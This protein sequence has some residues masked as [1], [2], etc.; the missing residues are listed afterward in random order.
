MKK[1][2]ARLV[3]WLVLGASI[4]QVSAQAK[5][6]KY[7]DSLLAIANKV[8]PDS[9]SVNASI[10]LQRYFF[11]RGRFD[12]ALKYAQQA[13]PIAKVV[14]TKKSLVRMMYRLGVTHTNLGAYDSAKVY[15]NEAIVSAVAIKDT[16]LE[17]TCY[18][19]FAQLSSYQSD[20][21]T[22]IEYSLRAVATID[23]S[24]SIQLKNLL[25]QTY[26]RIAYNFVNEKQYAKAIEYGKKG[27]IMKGYPSEGRH[28]TMLYLNVFFAY[29]E[30]G[31]VSTRK[32][33]LDS[34][35]ITNRSL[36][37]EVIAAMVFNNEGLYY[38]KVNDFEKAGMAYLKS[39]QLN[40]KGNHKLLQSEAGDNLSNIFYKTKNYQQ[41]EKYAIE[42]NAIGK[43]LKLYQVVASTYNVLK[44]LSERKGDF[45]NALAY[46]EQNKIYADSALNQET[47]KV[48]LSL[49]SKYQNQ[50]KEREIAALTIAN[51]QKE[52][53]VVKRN[54][55]LV[56]GGIAA[57]AALIILGLFYRN[58]RQKN[59]IAEQ[60][61]KYQQEQIKFL[62]RQQQVVS[63]QSMVNGQETERTRIAKDL[64]DGLGGLFS[65]VKMY[66][67]TL[68]HETPALKNNELF[69][70]SYKLVDTASEEVRSIAHNMMPE[71]LMKLGLTNALKDLCD[72]ISAS[73]L[74]QVSLAVHGMTKR[75]NATTEIMLFRIVQELLNN[76]IKHANATEAIIQFIRENE[77]LSVVVEDNG[78]GFNTQEA[79]EQNHSGIATIQSRVSYLNG[80]MSIDSQKNVGT[81]VMMDFLINESQASD[82]SKVS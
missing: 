19:A 16:L 80:K 7:I 49:E 75:L 30:L 71:V 64:H 57:S 36:D 59:L 21:V 60:E 20:Y 13:L 8:K 17:V 42:A 48:T 2:I 44:N 33:Y 34:A 76:I 54:Q 68:Q 39:Y 45:K 78:R 18:D 73:K 26:S 24:Q 12:S 32:M 31:N 46:A 66:F 65:T 79:D 37:N 41:A 15:L 47:Q 25:P 9:N 5:P 53:E 6:Q 22:S 23:K 29:L 81:T 72:N 69:Q 40:K 4:S 74:L 51:T 63:L 14:G 27:L 43:E 70:K 52:L 62:E 58:S 55:L 38:Q 61:K 56:A 1:G 10:Q 82:T 28:R 35:V 11:E 77:R 67:S 3:L 50:K